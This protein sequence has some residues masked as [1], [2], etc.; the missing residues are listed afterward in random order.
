MKI[1]RFLI[2]LYSLFLISCAGNVSEEHD[3]EHHH[4]GHDHEHTAPSEHEHGHAD[5]AIIIEPDDAQR[6]GIATETIEDQPINK[7]ISV[8]GQIISIPSGQ[9][10]ISAAGPGIVTLS[11]ILTPGHKLSAGQ[12]VGHISA[13]NISGGD[14]NA[15][16]RVAVNAAKQEVERL[17]PLVKEGIVTQREY[18]SALAAYEAAKAA[19]SPKAA[20]GALT[21]PITG[22]VTS[23]L[24]NTGQFVEAGTV[25]ATLSKSDKLILR[26]DL[27]EKFRSSL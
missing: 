16:A 7:A 4:H 6:L 21:S 14:P 12:S 8:T 5:G 1:I 13:Q 26:V 11:D 10:V 24:V 23:V 18:N 20:S 2:P 15:A 17:T 19:Y 9:A 22:I 25:I 27:P 3:H